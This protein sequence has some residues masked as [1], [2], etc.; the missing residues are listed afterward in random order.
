MR[1]NFVW[2]LPDIDGTTGV[3]RTL[4]WIAND[5]QV[6]GIWTGRT[7]SPY[8]V[9]FSYQSGGSSLNLTGSPDYPARVNVVGDPGNGCSDDLYRQFNAAAFAGPSAGSVGLES[10]NAY[11]R[12]C[13]SSVLDMSIMRRFRLGG[14]RSVQF[15]VDLFN[16]PNLAGITSR[17]ATMNLTNPLASTSVTNLPFDASGNL[18]EARSLP[19]NAGFGVA[20]GYQSPRTIQLQLRFEF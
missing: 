7:G 16:A 10:G 14:T 13:F 11:L 19:K 6:T 17:N 2:D 20:N 15:R 3:K 8:A 4:G 9:N 18:V 5:W 1:A 12:G